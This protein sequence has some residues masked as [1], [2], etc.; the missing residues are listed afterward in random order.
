MNN[1]NK[2]NTNTFDV[3]ASFPVADQYEPAYGLLDYWAIIYRNKWGVLGLT[4]AGLLIGGITAIT[5]KPSY[6]A[7][8]TLLVAPSQPNLVGM[9]SLD[10]APSTQ[11]FYETQYA[12]IRSRR[13]AETVVDNL[14]L[15]T[16]AGFLT[17]ANSDTNSGETSDETQGWFSATKKWLAE[18]GQDWQSAKAI[19]DPASIAASLR[20]SAVNLVQGNLK[21][22]SGQR[23]Q[24][25]VVQF[26]HNSA[27]LAA[28]VA[29]GV[30]K[31]YAEYGMASRMTT[32]QDATR[33]LSK[34]LVE[35]RQQLETSEATLQA[36][37]SRESLVDSENRKRIL[38]TQLS[39]LTNELL[40][41]QSERSEA[42]IRQQQIVE[43]RATRMSDQKLVTLLDDSLIQRLYGDHVLLQRK[44]SELSER[45][46]EKHPKLIAARADFEETNK[47]MQNKIDNAIASV[48][49]EYEAAVAKE[50]ETEHRIEAQQNQMRT[51][52]GK[53]DRKSTRL[54]SSHT[55]ISRM[56]SSA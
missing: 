43:A 47:S 13:I 42:Q 35:L 18:T 24:L 55:D 20:N 30:A 2:K 56:P 44:V 16:R 38:G 53:G 4:L 37:Q 34:R 9:Q 54:N 52:T 1:N 22:N 36:Y 50:R 31:A 39:N 26:E 7:S 11:F 48:K 6:R 41:A 28:E 17:T 25:V 12:I 15:P 14:K 32:V 5:A 27:R 51:V 40:H 3:P 45:Y 23:S 10:G 46:G 19:D 33:W 29:N 8:A 49:K 21:V